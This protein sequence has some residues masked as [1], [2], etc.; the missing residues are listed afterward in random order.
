MCGLY[1][2]P[3]IYQRDFAEANIVGDH[4]TTQ[5]TLRSVRWGLVACKSTS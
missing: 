2:A 3:N 5:H 1:G 4:H